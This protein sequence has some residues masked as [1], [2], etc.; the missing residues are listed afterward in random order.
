[1]PKKETSFCEKQFGF[2]LESLYRNLVM[3]VTTRR[4]I[5]SLLHFPQMPNASPL[6]Q[7]RNSNYLKVGVWCSPVSCSAATVHSGA[8]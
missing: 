6:A 5:F 2:L 1:M 3:Q 4:I 8:A 7:F